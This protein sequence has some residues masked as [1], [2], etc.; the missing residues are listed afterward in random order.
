MPLGEVRG[1]G[2]CETRVEFSNG[3][4]RIGWGRRG[5]GLDPLGLYWGRLV[6]RGTGELCD[7]IN[8]FVQKTRRRRGVQIGVH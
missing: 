5:S 7:V 4:R 6:G 8:S 1:V 2:S 3:S